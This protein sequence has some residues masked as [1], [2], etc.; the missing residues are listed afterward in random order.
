MLLSF[1]F[2]L[3]R[4]AAALDG[5]CALCREAVD[6][7]LAILGGEAANLALKCLAGGGVYIAGGIPPRLLKIIGADGGVLLDAFLHK[8]CRYTDVRGAFPLHII[9]ND[10]IGL[11]GAKVY[12]MRQL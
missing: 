8:Q 12:A 7:F 2:S 9:L 1:K 6:I 3:C 5:S 4:Y 10:K 11:A